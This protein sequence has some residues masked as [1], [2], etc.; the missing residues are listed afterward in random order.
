MI[1][2]FV[3]LGLPDAH[4]DLLGICQ[5]GIPDARWVEPD[6]LHMT[7]R[8]IGEVDEPQAQ[9]IHDALANVTAPGFPLKIAGVGYFAAGKRPRTIWAGIENADAGLTFL[10]AKI[11]RAIQR[12]GMDAETRRFTPHITLG[13]VFASPLNRLDAYVADNAG[14]SLPII[15]VDRFTLIESKLG[16]S[17][18]NYHALVDYP[19]IGAVLPG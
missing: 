7:L 19:L 13:R 4:R 3:G 9:D 1:R 16:K 2:L 10:Q 6:N 12:A 14:L 18:A 11:E 17:Q 5:H 15:N 8:F